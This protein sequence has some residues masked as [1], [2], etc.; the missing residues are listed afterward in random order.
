MYDAFQPIILGGLLVLVAVTTP[1]LWALT[2]RLDRSAR[3]R[4]HLLAAAADAS[5]SERRRIARDL[6]DGVVQELAGT[7]FALSA[8]ARD[9]QTSPET[10]A[11]LTPMS[12]ALRSSLRSLRSL[13]VEIYPPDLGVDGLGAAL[14]DL[15]APAAAAGVT[16]TV[17]VFGVESASDESVRLVWRVAQEAVRNALRHADAD[18]LSVQVRTVGSRLLLEVT[19]DGVGFVPRHGAP[20]AIGLRGLRDLIR[21]RR[22]AVSTYAGTRWGHHGARGGGAVTEPIRVVLVDDHAVV[23]A[24]LEQL[25]AGAG[26]IEVV[27]HGRRRG[28][29]RRGGARGPRPHVVLMDLQ[30]PGVDGVAATRQILADGLGA[31]VL[32]LTSYSDSERIV[33]AL[34][35]GAVGYLLKDADPED[36]LDGIR[37]VSRGE[38]PIHPRAARQL[39]A[40]RRRPRCGGSDLTPREAEVLGL[41]QAGAGQQADRPPARDQRADR[42]GAPDVGVPADRRRRPDPGRAVGRAQPRIGATGTV[43]RRERTFRVRRVGANARFG[44]VESARTQVSDPSSR[45]ERTFRGGRVVTALDTGEVAVPPPV[46]QQDVGALTASAG[47]RPRGSR[48]SSVPVLGVRSDDLKQRVLLP[49]T[50]DLEVVGGDAVLGEAVLQQDPLGCPIVN[51]RLAL[52]PVEPQFLERDSLSGCHRGG[53]NALTVALLRHPVA[54]AGGLERPPNDA[55]EVE[56]S[57]KRTAPVHDHH[58]ERRTVLGGFETRQHGALLSLVSE[59][60]LGPQRTRCGQERPIGTNE[61][62]QCRDVPALEGPQEWSTFCV[63]SGGGHDVAIS[64]RSHRLWSLMAPSM[65]ERPHIGRR[66]LGSAPIASSRVGHTR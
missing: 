39:L 56:R 51:K 27:G 52:D 62:G 2:R 48:S 38:S 44:S 11:R 50:S 9:P 31:D 40:S 30:M 24:G 28:R 46:T 23:R 20:A 35:A 55:V 3:D 57:D 6:H 22:A 42:Q 21:G 33:A 19:D 15:V 26:D 60:L 45:R 49:A 10:A 66:C 53:G 47:R 13:L 41:V 18:H 58:R 32:V 1:L 37:A 65:T 17:E 29:G 4:E 36:I 43:S 8:T 12:G 25:L 54:D 16:A 63:R 7:S 34:D 64:Y 61:P 5:E 14:Q 59:V